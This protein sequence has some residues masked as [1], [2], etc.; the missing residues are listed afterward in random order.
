MNRAW[1]YPTNDQYRSIMHSCHSR[2]PGMFS[3]KNNE[4]LASKYLPC[5]MKLDEAVP[6]AVLLLN[7]TKKQLQIV[8][9]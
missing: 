5:L 8:K 2:K 4:I 3:S 1:G 6:K 9:N 7:N